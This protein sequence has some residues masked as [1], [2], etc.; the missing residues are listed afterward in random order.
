MTTWDEEEVETTTAAPA[1]TE[2]QV[3]DAKLFGKWAI[4][5]ISV[6]DLSLS[7]SISKDHRVAIYVCTSC[8]LQHINFNLLL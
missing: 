7:V 5:D 1:G 8:L 2:I 4:N 3:Q 6:S